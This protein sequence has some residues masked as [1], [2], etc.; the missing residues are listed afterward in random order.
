MRGAHLRHGAISA[1]GAAV[2]ASKHQGH[3]LNVAP[4]R[5]PYTAIKRASLDP[6]GRLD[7]L[8]AAGTGRR[9]SAEGRKGARRAALA[10]SAAAGPWP[11]SATAAR[12]KRLPRETSQISAAIKRRALSVEAQ[13]VRR[14]AE[15]RGKRV[16]LAREKSP[17]L[18][19]SR[20][21]G[22]RDAAPP[23]PDLRAPAAN[24]VRRDVLASLVREA[25]LRH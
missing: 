9:G 23:R 7:L 14:Q 8:R 5:D 11:G 2:N 21:L 18:S 19:L 1:A 17:L 24:R 25:R 20:S 12:C 15:G 4:D 13:G 6:E 10:G 22:P 16:E 3:T